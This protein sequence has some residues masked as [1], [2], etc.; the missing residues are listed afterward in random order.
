MVPIVGS[1]SANAGQ[2]KADVDQWLAARKK[3]ES[4][5]FDELRS[6][7]V[8]CRNQAIEALSLDRSE[9]RRIAWWQKPI[10]HIF[11][12]QRTFPEISQ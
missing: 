5:H 9:I 8:D 10:L 3:I 4:E 2:K 11:S 7:E 6:L 1:N 12:V